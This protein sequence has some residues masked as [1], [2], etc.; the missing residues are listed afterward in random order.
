MDLA[1]LVSAVESLIRCIRPLIGVA[2]SVA[3]LLTMVLG[4]LGL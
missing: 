4:A 1:E 2:A 3:S